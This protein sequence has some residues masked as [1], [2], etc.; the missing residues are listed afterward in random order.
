M[1]SGATDPMQNAYF[2]AFYMSL[3]DA[4]GTV[5]VALCFG[6]NFGR[7]ILLMALLFVVG[8]LTFSLGRLQ[9][10]QVMLAVLPVAKAMSQA[11]A[12]LYTYTPEVFP[13]SFRVNGLAM[14]SIVHR[15]A[16]V[17]A[18]YLAA[19]LMEV[20]FAHV[21][22]AFGG[23]YLCGSV[24]LFLSVETA[25]RDVV[26]DGTKGAMS[27]TLCLFLS[28]VGVEWP[29]CPEHLAAVVA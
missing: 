15:F 14:C 21:T 25:G 6:A 10:V 8:V 7:R 29:V 16:P 24:S 22:T 1:N 26:E 20:F 27:V 9:N 2:A 3:G 18:P 19:A 13:T 12:V 5:F 28:Y 17:V 4:L 11:T 23:L